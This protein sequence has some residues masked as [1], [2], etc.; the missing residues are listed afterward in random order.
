MSNPRTTYFHHCQLKFPTRNAS[1]H[2]PAPAQVLS[3]NRNNCSKLSAGAFP[4]PIFCVNPGSVVAS[5]AVI[6]GTCMT[7]NI[8]LATLK[9]CTVFC[10]CLLPRSPNANSSFS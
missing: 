8:V 5:V 1:Y 9:T 3:A 4:P 2:P 10:R 6:I 7:V